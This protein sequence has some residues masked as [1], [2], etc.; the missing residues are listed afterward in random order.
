M[1]Q[2][3]TATDLRRWEREPAAIPVSLVLESDE[4][5]KDTFA[6]TLDISMSGAAVTTMLDLVPG[7]EV[8]IVF[9]GEFS[10]DIRARVIW[11]RKNESTNSTTAGLKFLL[12]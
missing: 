1:I 2:T 10:V 9:N 7:Q 8:A 6:A 4:S 5:Q 12:Y 11:V 3:M